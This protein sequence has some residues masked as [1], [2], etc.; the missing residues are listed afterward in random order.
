MKKK[1]YQHP[2]PEEK[3]EASSAST[4]NQIFCSAIKTCVALSYCSPTD[5]F[6][7]RISEAESRDNYQE[8]FYVLPY[9]LVTR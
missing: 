1:K 4:R 5:G 6:V 3:V 7:D 2:V 9:F 8:K